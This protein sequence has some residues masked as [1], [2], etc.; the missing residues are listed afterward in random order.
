MNKTKK[1]AVAAVSLV[2]AG[3]MAVSIAACS[4]KTHGKF[5]DAAQAKLEVSLDESGRLKYSSDTTLNVN[6]G[7][8]NY[9]SISYLEAGKV[10]SGTVT[11]P[12]GKQ[13][14]SGDLK[15]TWANL[16]TKLGLKFNDVYKADTKKLDE[17]D[18]DKASADWNIVTDSA[19]NMTTKGTATPELLLDFNQYLD[20]MPNYKA[21][22]DANAVVRLALTSDTETGAMYYAP[23][24]DGDNDVEK[25][26]MVKKNWV[27]ALLDNE[28][29]ATSTTFA[30]QAT[31]KSASDLDGDKQ[32]IDG[33]AASAEAFMGKTDWSIVG[34]DGNT[35]INIKYSDALTAAKG[36]TGLGAA[37]TAAAGKAYTGDSGN[38]VDIMNFI[39]NETEGNVTGDKLLKVVQEYI[40]VAYKIG[41]N[42][43][44]ATRSD[45]FNGLNAA[46][47]ADLMT[48][49]FRCVV[50]NGHVLNSGSGKIGSGGT[51]ENML[52]ALAAREKTTQRT[53]DIVALAG[54]LFG[55]RGLESRFEYTYIDN[56]GNLR[57]AR[58]DASTYEALA[59]MN[60][61]AKEGLLYFGQASNKAVSYYTSNSIE[62]LMMHDYSQTQTSTGG[63]A[64]QKDSGGNALIPNNGVETDYD[65]E[66]ILTAVS[67]WDTNCDGTAETI[68]RFTESW[69]SIKNTGFCVPYDS[70]KGSPEKL[71]AVLAF[72]DYIF[73][74]EGQIDFTF[75]PQATA[76]DGTNGFWYNPE[77]NAATH[78]AEDGW[79][80]FT[81]NGKT[82]ASKT[83]YK[84]GYIP[85]VTNSMMNLF[86][87]KTVNG[88]FLPATDADKQEIGYGIAK[89]PGNYT[90][91][92]RNVIG[93]TLPLG[94]KNQGFEYQCTAACGL[95][96]TAIVNEAV[97]NGAIK[98]VS[99]AIT[100][101]RWYIE[102]P[103]ALPLS[104]Q[105][106]TWVGA[107]C[108]D[109]KTSIF[110]NSSSTNRNLAIYV[111]FNGFNTDI[112]LVKGGKKMPATAAEIVTLVNETYQ[113]KTYEGYMKSA[114][115]AALTMYDEII[116]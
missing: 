62:A 8:K 66:P 102:A 27:K 92:A 51:A 15:P 12:D 3:T 113:L 93:S 40:D 50:T 63:F 82:Y 64:V 38:I 110:V 67:K 52:Y 59:K 43:A 41:G 97:V 21:Y 61:L 108:K 107:N 18:K 13:Y 22:L 111:M 44:Y 87:G 20:Y 85:T 11:L 96:G 79:G 115:S 56:G 34:G 1:I 39:I 23:Y 46:W 106:A 83:K 28:P 32:T 6:I 57:D 71:S 103:T 69:R 14:K 58:S 53:M 105:Q 9:R 47:D 75:G 25:Y 68:M 4:G 95:A 114:W 48:A 112:E 73:S 7:D 78:K 17:M 35:T 109:L 90:D 104:S 60:A 81:Y 74:P 116:K 70:V 37:V 49:L 99:T 10:L 76:E 30:S 84:A 33:T 72:V 26:T 54:E 101:N 98:H 91:T 77:Y 86:Y 31:A 5:K 55:A 100:N 65:F 80:K 36:T 88:F 29:S 94:L 89:L 19:D 24:F 2:M 45:V 16:Q 42:K